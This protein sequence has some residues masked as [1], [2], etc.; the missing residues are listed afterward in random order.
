[1]AGELRGARQRAFECWR[2]AELLTKDEGPCAK[3]GAVVAGR[4]RKIAFLLM[5]F[6]IDFCATAVA[7]K[8]RPFVKVLYVPVSSA[9]RLG[10]F[11]HKDTTR[12]KEMIYTGR[13]A[14]TF[15]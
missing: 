5:E 6:E 1:M 9:D 2:R 13:R 15:N 11:L 7:R 4:R 3:N 10:D 14:V 8:I 12:Y